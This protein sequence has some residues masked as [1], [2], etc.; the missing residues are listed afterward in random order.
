MFRLPAFVAF[1]L[2]ATPLTAGLLASSQQPPAPAG[3]VVIKEPVKDLG[4]VGLGT[5]PEAAFTI[6]NRGGSALEISVLPVATGLK[7]V[8]AD[9]SIAPAA[10]GTVR[11]AV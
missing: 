7:V 5:D 4:I 6:E 3:A 10:S 9:R 11:V 2:L 8:S 1:L